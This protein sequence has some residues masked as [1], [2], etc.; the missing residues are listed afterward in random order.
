MFTPAEDDVALALEDEAPKDDRLPR[1]LAALGLAGGLAA[2]ASVLKGKNEASA[3]PGQDGLFVRSQIVTESANVPNN[4]NRV[5]RMIC[6]NRSG[7]DV[8]VMGGG[9][10]TTTNNPNFYIKTSAPDTPRSWL[11]DAHNVGS[12]APHTVGGYAICVYFRS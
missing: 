4:T 9:F 2:L 8:R 12:G 6:P 7:L 5:I 11:V 10:N 3:H 1:R